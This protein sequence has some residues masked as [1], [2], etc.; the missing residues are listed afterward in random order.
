MLVRFWK[1]VQ[2]PI[3]ESRNFDFSSFYL[4][5]FTL[6]ISYCSSLSHC[7]ILVVL[8]SHDARDDDKWRRSESVRVSL[9][10]E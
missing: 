7:R 3:V 5:P 4:S 10:K 6:V 9:R 8:T 1:D 2:I